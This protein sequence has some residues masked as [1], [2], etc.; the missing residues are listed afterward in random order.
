MVLAPHQR[1][2]QRLRELRQRAS[3][4]QADVAEKAGICASHVSQIE[5]GHRNPGLGVLLRLLDVLAATPVD[6]A[7]ILLEVASSARD[8][9]QPSPSENDQARGAA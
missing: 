5:S 6:Q 8:Q 3:L 9:R 1:Q 7:A 2:R 4:T